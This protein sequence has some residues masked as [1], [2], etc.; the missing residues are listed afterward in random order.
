MLKGEFNPDGKIEFSE[1]KKKALDPRRLQ[2]G[3]FM[4]RLDLWKAPVKRLKKVD[5]PEQQ[6]LFKEDNP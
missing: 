6:K 3:M 1:F 2:G 4:D 5:P